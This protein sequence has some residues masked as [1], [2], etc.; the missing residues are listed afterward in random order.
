[1]AVAEAVGR[2]LPAAAAIAAAAAAAA[3]S[4]VDGEGAEGVYA[5][6]CGVI[7]SELFTCVRGCGTDKGV[8]DGIENDGGVIGRMGVWAGAG[9][10]AAVAGGD[11]DGVARGW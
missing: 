6:G 4:A 3:V 2:E 7:G 9:G 1:M 11:E 5:G 10:V 8:K